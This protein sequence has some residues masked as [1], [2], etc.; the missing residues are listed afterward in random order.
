MNARD[1]SN[2]N[3]VSLI[4]K[5]EASFITSKQN[6]LFKQWLLIK[7]R[8][9]SNYCLVEGERL[10]K[11]LYATENYKLATSSLLVST[12]FWQNKQVVLLN[13]FE[14]L[15]NLTVVEK[16]PQVYVLSEALYKQVASTVQSQ[17]IIAL[18][19]L[20]LLQSLQDASD[21]QKKLA[22]A[23][24]WQPICGLKDREIVLVLDEVQDPGNLGNIIRTA[25]AFG[26]KC[27]YSLT[28]TV[29]AWQ[30]KV[31]RSTMGGIFKLP[32][33]E[34]CQS[35]ILLADLKKAG[36]SLFAASLSEQNMYTYLATCPSSQLQK[37][38]LIVGNEGNGVGKECL[39]AADAVLTIPM[40]A[41]SES[42]NVATAT[43]LCLAE[44]RFH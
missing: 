29:H 43:A 41:A 6:H 38:A 16:L 25:A 12:E 27:I 32:I 4:V 13:I 20:N 18:L 7:K 1:F 9:Q 10:V 24:E 22:P 2:L 31:L 34:N 33:K 36:Y 37:V 8:K 14:Q 23:V 39:A 5:I 40:L 19:D 42:L 44:L 30:D 17:G 26:V 21:L 28:G 3:L 11:E 15:S 35:A